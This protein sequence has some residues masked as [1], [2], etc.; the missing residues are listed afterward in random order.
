MPLTI[1]QQIKAG[2][3]YFTKL[4]ADEMSYLC[5]HCNPKYP[6]RPTSALAVPFGLT[7]QQLMTVATSH[8]KFKWHKNID[9]QIW[10]SVFATIGVKESKRKYSITARDFESAF[11]T[12]V[13]LSAKLEY[14]IKAEPE[15]PD[16]YIALSDKDPYPNIQPTDYRP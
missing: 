8:F 9:I 1:E 4:V 7:G 16:F 10:E 11:K 5:S 3:E 2:E 13:A 12:I 15:S 14:D 6:N